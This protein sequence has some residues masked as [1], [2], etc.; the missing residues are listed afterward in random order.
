MSDDSRIERILA[1]R[2]Q[3]GFQPAGWAAQVFDRLHMRSKGNSSGHFHSVS[4]VRKKQRSRQ[5]TLRVMLERN[6]H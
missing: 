2:I 4:F 3:Q 6:A 1:T 5:A